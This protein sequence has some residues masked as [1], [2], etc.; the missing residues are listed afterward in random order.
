[1]L[2]VKNDITEGLECGRFDPLTAPGKERNIIVSNRGPRQG[3]PAVITL[4]KLEISFFQFHLIIS[5]GAPP[6][7]GG[8][9]RGK[10]AGP[11]PNPKLPLTF[12]KSSPSGVLRFLFVE[13]VGPK[14]LNG[15]KQNRRQ[16]HLSA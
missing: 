5:K 9:T 15:M 3:P 14:N 10:R 13:T 16:N 1:M 2:E 12:P 4:P 8:K 11:W 6:A 7:I